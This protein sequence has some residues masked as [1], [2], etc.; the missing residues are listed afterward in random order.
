MVNPYSRA[1][2]KTGNN[3]C[4]VTDIIHC[5]MAAVKTNLNIMLVYHPDGFVHAF[6]L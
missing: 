2:P 1:D 3:I 6:F 5:I 4:H